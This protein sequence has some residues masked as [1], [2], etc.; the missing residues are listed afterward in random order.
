MD[1]DH[2]RGCGEHRSS[3]AEVKVC[4]GSSPR[5]RGALRQV[6]GAQHPGRHRRDARGI[7]PADAGSTVMIPPGYGSCGD[8]PRGCGE[9]RHLA[10]LADSGKGSSPRMRGAPGLLAKVGRVVGIIPAD[11]GSTSQPISCRTPSRDHPRGCGE[12]RAARGST[13][14]VPG[15][16]PRMRGAPSCRVRDDLR[17]GIIPAHAGSTSSTIPNALPRDGSSPRMRGARW[18]LRDRPRGGGIIPADAGSTCRV[19]EGPTTVGD[20]PRGCGEHRREP[21][22]VHNIGGSS[23]RM[24]GARAR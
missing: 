14:I 17:P 11:A 20:H 12:H 15:S 18:R 1:W 4:L 8:H 3:H 23:P 2:P 24:R 9:H 22:S 6:R 21:G 16:S 7:I 10:R 19:N 5:M 13:S